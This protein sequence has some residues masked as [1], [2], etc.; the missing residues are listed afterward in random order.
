MTSR[1]CEG[2]W[3]IGTGEEG[4][5]TILTGVGRL[6]GYQICEPKK[7]KE[8]KWRLRKAVLCSR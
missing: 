5:L 7:E 6:N 8:K 3:P 1:D 4:G 2:P